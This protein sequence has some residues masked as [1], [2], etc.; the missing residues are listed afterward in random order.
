MNVA[1][2]YHLLVIAITLLKCKNVI[3]IRKYVGL[4]YPYA[5]VKNGLAQESIIFICK[6][7]LIDWSKNALLVSLSCS[8]SITTYISM[9][10]YESKAYIMF[11]IRSFITIRR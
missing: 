7:E 10:I 11:F 8:W 6:V 4:P 5:K 1:I 9:Y 2:F 3:M